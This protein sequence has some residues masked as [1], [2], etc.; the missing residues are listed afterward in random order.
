MIPLSEQSES[1]TESKFVVARGGADGKM[2]SYCL[3]V[4]CFSL[5]D[6]KSYRGGQWLWL[7]IINIF[8][9]PELYS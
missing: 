8:N 1:Q 4:E 2:G 9:D 3:R 5:Q 6:E 7:H